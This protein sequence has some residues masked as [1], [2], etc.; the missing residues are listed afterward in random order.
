MF[1][2]NSVREGI[3]ILLIAI[4]GTVNG[5]ILGIGN[6][7]IFQTPLTNFLFI[8]MSIFI[9]YGIGLPLIWGVCLGGL[10]GGCKALISRG[11]K[12][13]E[14]MKPNGNVFLGVFP[15]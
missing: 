12:W 7:I 15:T 2:V 4:M 1:E 5:L 13:E 8:D 10:A 14:W 9:L 11:D 6:W 3:H